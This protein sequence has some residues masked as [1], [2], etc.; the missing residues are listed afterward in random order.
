MFLWDEDLIDEFYRALV[1]LLNF[2][3]F[4]HAKELGEWEHTA[5]PECFPHHTLLQGGKISTIRCEK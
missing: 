3:R 4:A 2:H 1:P 5:F